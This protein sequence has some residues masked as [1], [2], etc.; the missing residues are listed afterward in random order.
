MSP[1]DSGPLKAQGEQLGDRAVGLSMGS[2]RVEARGSDALT[3]TTEDAIKAARAFPGVNIVP[4]YFEVWEHFTEGQG[5]I[6]KAFAQS[7]ILPGAI[8]ILFPK[9]T[10]TLAVSPNR[11]LG[12]SRKNTPYELR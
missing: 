8:G 10:L 6:L 1:L 2:A 9:N 12:G 3:M 5:D 7:G 4:N 11:L